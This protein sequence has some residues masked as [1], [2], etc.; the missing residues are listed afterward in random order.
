[1][2]KVERRPQ[3]VRDLFEIWDYVARDNDA[4]ADRLLRPFDDKLS[5]LSD[6]PALGKSRE[7]LSPGLRSF[8]VGEYVLFYRPIDGGVTLVAALHGRRNIDLLAELG[9]F[10]ERG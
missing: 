9:L 3:A 1:V 8:V 6:A 5:L 2:G 7:D 10:D 4:A